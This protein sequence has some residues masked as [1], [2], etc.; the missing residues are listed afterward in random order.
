MSIGLSEPGFLMIDS[1]LNPVGTNSEAVEILAFPAVPEKIKKL[2]V[3]LTDKVR[4]TLIKR[5]SSDGGLEFVREFKSGK[6]RYICRSF[7]LECNIKG[8]RISSVLLLERYSS[9]SA[10]LEQVAKQFDLTDRER[11]TVELLLQGLTSKEIAIRMGI[12]PN[13]V[14]AFLRL[15][16][17]KM[18][19]ST[20]SGIVG[21][22]S[23]PYA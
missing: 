18:G 2:D 1:S 22:V 4:S 19:V 3:F 21:R 12:S 11:E 17:V 15:V 13:T 5:Q 8:F 10:A 7:R 16:M 20:R 23:G 9:G 6:R 14:K